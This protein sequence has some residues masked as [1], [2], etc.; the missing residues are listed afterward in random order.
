MDVASNSNETSINS[1]II[2]ESKRKKNPAQEDRGSKRNQDIRKADKAEI[3]LE[4]K[5]SVDNERPKSSETVKSQTDDIQI[6]TNYE[7]D[8]VLLEK[9]DKVY[10]CVKCNRILRVPFLFEDCG[11][12]CCSGC[13]PD[14]FRN[15]SKCPADKQHLKKDRVHLDKAFQE[16]MD[17]LGVK[18]SY[19]SQGCVWTGVL[20][21]LGNHLNQCEYKILQCP[22]ECGVEIQ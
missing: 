10:E 21:E 4:T 11:H 3:C 22:R 9:L 17:R 14:I 19:H 18:C 15:T 8:I 2:K 5:V 6:K 20:N 1:D 12:R 7:A 16:H 13:V